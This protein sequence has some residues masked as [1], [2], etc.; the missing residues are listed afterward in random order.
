M[1]APMQFGLDTFGDVTFGADGKQLS[2]AQV[3][4]NVVG[5]PRLQKT[6]V[7]PDQSALTLTRR[8]RRAYAA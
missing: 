2:Q 3:L 8:L 6:L 4:R 7:W 1:T 5:G